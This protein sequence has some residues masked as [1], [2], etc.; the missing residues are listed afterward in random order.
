MILGLAL[1]QELILVTIT[2]MVFPQAK[3]VLL[4]LEEFMT[5]ILYLQQTKILRLVLTS[6]DFRC[7][8]SACYD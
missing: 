7:G 1:Q 2:D 3:M 6:Y 8:F 5:V 4:A